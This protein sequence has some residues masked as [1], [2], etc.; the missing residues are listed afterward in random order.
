LWSLLNYLVGTL[1]RTDSSCLCIR[2][3]TWMIKEMI[4]CLESM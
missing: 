4:S 2:L 3:P 1:P